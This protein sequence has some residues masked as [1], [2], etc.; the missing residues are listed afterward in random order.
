MYVVN[1]NAFTPVD[2]QQ[3]CSKKE[4]KQVPRADSKHFLASSGKDYV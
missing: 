3:H 4:S 1:T 2:V